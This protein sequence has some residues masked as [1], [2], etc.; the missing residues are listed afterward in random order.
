MLNKRATM[1][2][3]KIFKILRSEFDSVTVWDIIMNTNIGGEI[4]N[5]VVKEWQIKDAEQNKDAIIEK[6][7]GLKL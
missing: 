2:A 3:E 4:N 7:K 1:I 5:A 6:L